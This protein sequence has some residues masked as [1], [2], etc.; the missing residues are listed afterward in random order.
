VGTLIM[1]I[2][3]AIQDSKTENAEATS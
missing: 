1:I 2:I 3:G